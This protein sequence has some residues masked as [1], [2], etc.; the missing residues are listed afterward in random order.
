MS[1]PVLILSTCES[2]EDARRIA[3]HLVERQLAA[4]VNLL[5]G[6]ASI[7]RWKGQ[8][9]EA[10]EVLLMI[11]TTRALVQDIQRE[12]RSIHPYE[13]PELVVLGIAGGSA[14]Y[15]AW[16]EENLRIP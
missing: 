4:C 3:H 11:K 2:N 7:Y 6:V 15:L 16:L 12:F 1:E 8:L 14:A 13:T 9:E 10:H 5:P